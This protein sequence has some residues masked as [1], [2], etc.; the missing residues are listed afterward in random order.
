M[1]ESGNSESEIKSPIPNWINITNWGLK[2]P[3][4]EY[5]PQFG[6]S[7]PQLGIISHW[8]FGIYEYGNAE[9]E[10]KSPIPNWI[11]ITNWG[12]EIPNW[13]YYTQLGILFC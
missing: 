11:N 3:N 12:F 5:Y 8:E 7:N 4:W 1:Y 10:N 13:G 6:I 9:S 2:I